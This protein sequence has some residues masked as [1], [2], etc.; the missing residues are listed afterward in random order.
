MANTKRFL[1]EGRVPFDWLQQATPEQREVYAILMLA[2]RHAHEGILLSYKRDGTTPSEHGGRTQMYRVR[3][4]GVEALREDTYVH[5]Y[6]AVA[7]TGTLHRVLI[8]DLTDGNN[9]IMDWE[10]EWHATQKDLLLEA[11]QRD[12]D[13]QRIHAE[14]ETSMK[15]KHFER[16]PDAGPGEVFQLVDDK[17][18]E[19]TDA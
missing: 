4:S 12:L 13:K 1:I 15:G 11:M 8:T 7:L 6:E 19:A 9:R 10:G 5:L 18:T 17:P 3:I 16:V 14:V 2:P